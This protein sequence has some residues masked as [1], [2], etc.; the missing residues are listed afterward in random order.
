MF[1]SCISRIMTFSA[2]LDDQGHMTHKTIVGSNYELLE[3]IRFV[4]YARDK[5]EDKSFAYF[6]FKTQTQS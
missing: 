6:L 4:A 3:L 5:I 2:A 1:E